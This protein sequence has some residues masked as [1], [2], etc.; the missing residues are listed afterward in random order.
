MP[1]F[2][3]GIS[4]RHIDHHLAKANPSNLHTL[5]EGLKMKPVNTKLQIGKQ[6][7]QEAR[8]YLQ[9]HGLLLLEQNYRSPFGEIDL[10]LRD[11]D[12]IVFIEVRYRSRTDYGTAAETVNKRKQMKL[13]KTAI[14]FLQRK[15][16]LN[17][18]NGR[19]DII[20]IHATFTGSW[21]IEW[22]KNAFSVA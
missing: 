19:F 17:K 8:A 15:K 9:T 14:H 20:A 1:A 11:S 16:W 5:R 22:F 18:V 3:F 6:A 21:Q 12:D 2:S 4:I 13:Y 7:E 10:I